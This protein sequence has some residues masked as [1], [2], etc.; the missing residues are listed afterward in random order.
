MVAL[1]LAQNEDPGGK[2]FGNLTVL[3]RCAKGKNRGDYR[4]RCGCACG[5]VLF[6]KGSKLRK[7]E[8]T[9]CGRCAS[10]FNH[11]IKGETK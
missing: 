3:T 10:A 11:A 4:Y 2:V 8:V 9:Q 1:N 6:V 5:K 7:G